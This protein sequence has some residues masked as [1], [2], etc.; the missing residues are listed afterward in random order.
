MSEESLVKK[1]TTRGG[2][3]FQTENAS[4]QAS[5]QPNEIAIDMTKESI[6]S[7]SNVEVSEKELLRHVNYNYFGYI[8]EGQS[9]ILLA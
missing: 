9:I 8:V 1:D 2:H 5:R 4:V 6:E 3:K 7:I